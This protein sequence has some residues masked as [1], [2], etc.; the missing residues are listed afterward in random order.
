MSPSS[1]A[2]SG[3]DSRSNGNSDVELDALVMNL[4]GHRQTRREADAGAAQRGGRAGRQRHRA[5]TSRRLSSPPTSSSRSHEKQDDPRDLSTLRRVCAKC[6]SSSR[7]SS[8]CLKVRER[9]NTQVQEEMGRNQREYVLRQQ[10]KAIKEE[11]GELDEGGGDLEEFKE[12]IAKA[13]MPEEAEKAAQQTARPPQSDAALV[14]RVHGHSH[15]SRVARRAAVGRSVPKTKSS[16]TKFVRCSTRITTTSKRSRS[17]SSNTWR[18]ASSKIDKK[19]P[20]LCLVGPSWESVRRLWVDRWPAPSAA[21]SS[22][23]LSVAY[24][25]RPRFAGTDAPTSGRYRAASFRASRKAGP[26]TQCLSSTRSTSSVTI[27]AATRPRRCS[28]S[29]IRNRTTRSPTTTSKCP[30]ICRR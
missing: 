25:T 10:L 16:S 5:G 30:S 29:S 2:Q 14:G 3:V 24:A 6:C 11:L 9:I 4:K 26:T 8:R 7:V 27:S 28:R 1:A 18:C 19:G 22:A 12:K 20:I 17:A 21:N 23:F 15:L 13:E